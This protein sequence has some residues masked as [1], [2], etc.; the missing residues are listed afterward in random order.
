MLGGKPIKQQVILSFGS[1]LFTSPSQPASF[2]LPLY[3]LQVEVG[4]QMP[5]DRKLPVAGAT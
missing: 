4:M 3:E 1:P 5:S 2:V